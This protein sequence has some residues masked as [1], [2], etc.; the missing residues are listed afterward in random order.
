[1]ANLKLIDNN[2]LINRECTLFFNNNYVIVASSE[3]V[4]EDNLPPYEHIAANN[5]SLHYGFIE[6]YT[7]YLVNIKEAKLN[8]KIRFK[9]DKINLTHNQSLCLFKNTFTVLSQQ[10]QTV[11]IYNIVP[12]YGS[13]RN[14]KFL[15]IDSR[16]KFH[17]I[18]FK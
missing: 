10:N 16:F 18:Y 13:M 5:E 3:V 2:E 4:S 1:M 9:A 7:I 8:D 17:L 12:K 15:K 11:H 6:N 14:G